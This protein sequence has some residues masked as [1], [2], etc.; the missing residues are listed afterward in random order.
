MDTLSVRTR[1]AQPT[2]A[3]KHKNT[4]KLKKN[5]EC[6]SYSNDIDIMRHKP[7]DVIVRVRSSVCA[8]REAEH[9]GRLLAAL[10]SC[11]FAIKIH[12]HTSDGMAGG[13]SNALNGI[14]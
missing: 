7:P 12:V 2:T 3:P 4:N 11:I 14:N 10:R 13:K 5:I 6:V 1:S 8:E 9:F